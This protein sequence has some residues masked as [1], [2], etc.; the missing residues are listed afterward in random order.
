LCVL[1]FAAGLAFH[2]VGVNVHATSSL[3]RTGPGP[4]SI[5]RRATAL[6][7]KLCGRL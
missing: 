4:H 2:A 6:V 7:A 3:A 5:K 1:H